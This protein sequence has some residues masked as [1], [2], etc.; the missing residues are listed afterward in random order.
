MHH[1]FLKRIRDNVT[2]ELEIEFS[3]NFDDSQKWLVR[4]LIKEIMSRCKGLK[5]NTCDHGTIKLIKS[6]GYIYR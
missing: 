5:I 3:D 6:K 2:I 1:H 4:N